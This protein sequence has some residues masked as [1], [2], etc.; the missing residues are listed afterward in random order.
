VFA[1]EESFHPAPRLQV[2]L[3]LAQGKPEQ[4]AMAQDA[5]E[6]WWWPV[7]DDVWAPTMRTP[8]TLPQSMKWNIKR[9]SND[10]LRQRFV[11]MTVPQAELLG[12]T[13]SRS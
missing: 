5:P 12:L 11:D 3:T 4:K 7:V 2:M 9:F 10:E 8:P 13:P 1:K 6:R